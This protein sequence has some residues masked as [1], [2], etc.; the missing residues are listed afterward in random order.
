[1]RRMKE[2]TYF[3]LHSAVGITKHMGGYKATNEIIELCKIKKG[4]YVLD[5]GC[6]V[7]KT[8]WYLAKKF[9]CRVIGIDLSEKMLEWARKRTKDCGLEDKIE[10]IKAD[11]TKMP[12]KKNTFDAVIVQSVTTFIPDKQKALK[13]YARVVKKNGYVGMNEEIWIKKP[14]TKIE[15]AVK[16]AIE[17]K[18]SLL[19][20]KEWI[21]LMKKSGLKEII[22]RPCK[23]K[24]LEQMWAE[25]KWF[26]L[27]EMV[28][29]TYLMIKLFIT[30]KSFRK[31]A[32]KKRKTPLNVFDY[33]GYG[34][35]VGKK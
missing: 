6:G 30:S 23:P 28:R 12:F 4:S 21:D 34:I 26:E 16:E 11:A 9:G 29:A 27:K 19:Y 35:F 1:M 2:M 32:M 5:V 8:S 10:F 22:S 25:I 13:E 17:I 18:T 24:V 20:E 3:E 7:G 31:Y 33:M 15:C 14:T